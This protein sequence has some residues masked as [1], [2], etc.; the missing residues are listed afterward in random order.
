MGRMNPLMTALDTNGD[1]E[2]SEDE[3]QQATAS[4]KTLDKNSDGRLTDEEVRPPAGGGG[5]R[6]FGGFGGG[7][8]PGGEEM[9]NRL[10]EYDTDKD[11]KVSE[12][13]LPERMKGMMRGD[14]DKD[15]A[16]SRDEIVK[17]SQSEGGFGR[18]GGGRGE[19]GP[20]GGRGGFGNPAEFV[21]RLMEL[22]ADKDE[23][24]SREE[25]SKMQFPAFGGRQGGP[26]G[27]PNG[28][29]GQP[30]NRPPVEN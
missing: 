7:R 12:A 3:L 29:G 4:L 22:D 28:D 14:S 15:G 21:N 10:M 26:G 9:A 8:G 5:E 18:G 16:L 11:G 17:S 24:L 13:E 6:G 2:I 20:G 27:R 19:G 1:R 25:L 23:K 30:R